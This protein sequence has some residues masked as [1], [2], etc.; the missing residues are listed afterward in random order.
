[1]P[2][3]CSRYLQ[4]VKSFR[5]ITQPSPQANPCILITSSTPH[6]TSKPYPNLPPPSLP[7]HPLAF[8]LPYITITIYKPPSLTAFPL[9]TNSVQHN[10]TPVVNTTLLAPAITALVFVIY[11][12]VY[13]TRVARYNAQSVLSVCAGRPAT[14]PAT[15]AAAKRPRFSKPLDC[16]PS[17]R[18]IRSLV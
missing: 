5:M 4:S 18:I 7:S 2:S 15:T 14:F 1:M 3:S 6:L 13:T 11:S 10:P 12:P 17:Q 9:L 16:A 8:L